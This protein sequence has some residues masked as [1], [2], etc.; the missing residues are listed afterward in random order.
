MSRKQPSFGQLISY[1]NKEHYR[2]DVRYTRNLYAGDHNTNGVIEEMEENAT[3]LPKR[4]NGNYLYHE[5]ISL[6]PGLDVS[7]AKQARI[8]HDLV[9]QY[10][11]R[12]APNQM[13]YGKLHWETDHLHFHLAISANEARGNRRIWMSKASLGRIQR[14]VERYK[15]EHYPEL[16]REKYYDQTERRRDQRTIERVSGVEITN[17]EYELKRRTG[18]QTRKEQDRAVL[19]VIFATALS[20]QELNRQLHGAGFNLYRR[21]TTEGV[22]SRETGRKYRL[23]TLGLSNDMQQA[24][25]RMKV[26]AERQSQLREAR[27]EPKDRTPNRSRDE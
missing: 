19:H 13:V 11:K 25:N 23:K 18:E 3:F 2:T 1:F 24:R 20:E 5:V 9:D 7:Q 6:E 14:D 15:I 16:G 8:L 21:G 12:R 4:A 10:I 17:R 27:G 22:I 26:Y